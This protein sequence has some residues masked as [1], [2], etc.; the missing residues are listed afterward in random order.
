MN[1]IT[2]ILQYLI[3]IYC[4]NHSDIVFSII[5]INSHIIFHTFFWFPIRFLNVAV[6]AFFLPIFRFKKWWSLMFILKNINRCIIISSEKLF[7]D[8]F[9]NISKWIHSNIDHFEKI[10]H[11]TTWCIMIVITHKFDGLV[12][13]FLTVQNRVNE[14]KR[15]ELRKICLIIGIL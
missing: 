4:E 5:E 13:V 12:S 6:F 2:I 10:K 14:Q 8:D 9:L 1:K 11:F 7:T 3:H 15:Y